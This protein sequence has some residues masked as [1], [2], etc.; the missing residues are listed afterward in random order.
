MDIWSYFAHFVPILAHFR[1]IFAYKNIL[2]AAEVR[3]TF[4]FRKVITFD[5]GDIFK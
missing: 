5:Y 1:V 2:R 4:R 3:K